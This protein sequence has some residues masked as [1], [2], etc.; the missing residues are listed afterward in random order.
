MGRIYA[1][2]MSW[3]PNFSSRSPIKL[4]YSVHKPYPTLSFCIHTLIW[5]LPNLCLTPAWPLPDPNLTSTWPQPD[6]Y[7][8]STWPLPDPY[9]T[10]T[11]LPDPYLIPTWP[12][13]IPSWPLP[14][15]SVR[16][17]KSWNLCSSFC[18]EIGNLNFSHIVSLVLLFSEK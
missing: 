12:L 6:P 1:P 14:D 18:V 10:P 8:T 17:D 3:E 5:S 7:L 15:P 2:V 4:K 9:L 11:S 13:P 16:Q